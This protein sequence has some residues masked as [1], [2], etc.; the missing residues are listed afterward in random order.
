MSVT[1]I[2]DRVFFVCYNSHRKIS[3]EGLHL[4]K[5]SKRLIIPML[6]AA[7]L[8]GCSGKPAPAAG[9]T[10][11]IPAAAEAEP[12]KT[13]D[14]ELLTQQITDI[15]NNRYGIWSVYVEAPDTDFAVEVNNC[16]LRAASTI[17]LFNMVTFYDE[18]NK[19][20]LQT[21]D[22]LNHSL[23]KMITVSSNSDSNVIVTA[24]GGGDFAAGAEKVTA[25]AKDMGCTFTQEQHKLYDTTGP[26]SGKNT[27]S[28]KD[29]AL[30][31]KKIYNEECISPKYD[32]Q[33]LDLLKKQTRTGKIPGGVPK[34]T[35]VANKTG[36]HSKAELD[37][38]IVYSPECTYIICIAV[39]DYGNSAVYSTF[40]DISR[41]VYNF[42]NPDAAEEEP[43][44]DIKVTV[45]PSTPSLPPVTE[46][47]PEAAPETAPEAVPEATPD[48]PEAIL[49]ATPDQ[50][51]DTPVETAE[52]EAVALP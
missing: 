7:L 19:G 5:L 23:N 15:T 9:D 2:V 24:I 48:I 30:I 8:G 39:T 46:T 29:C 10:A 47:T 25:L 20:N 3:L 11:S 49:D 33:M 28:V 43:V 17:K 14:K 27:T 45:K 44:S 40:R 18:M 51:T 41:T 22:S 52:S 6:L 12:Q 35:V 37:V 32:R 50:P 42:F 13:Y 1:A 34:G 21:N 36:E 4:S 26:A 16:Q 31:L 38:G